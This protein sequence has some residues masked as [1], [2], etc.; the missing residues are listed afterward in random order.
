MRQPKTLRTSYCKSF[1]TNF[2]KNNI[3]L[4]S[5]EKWLAYKI[6]TSLNPI[7]TLIETTIRS[8]ESGNQS[9]KSNNLKHDNKNHHL[10]ANSS[11]QSHFGRPHA[12]EG[13]AETVTKFQIVLY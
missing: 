12:D 11:S 3:N 10:N 5:F 13:F 8:K 7:A 1:D 2:N 6:Q 9:D 4:I